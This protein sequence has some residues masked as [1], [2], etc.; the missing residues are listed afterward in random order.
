MVCVFREAYTNCGYSPF[1]SF[2]VIDLQSRVQ[3]LLELGA[4]LDGPIKYAEQ[5][6]I[7]ALR[8]PDGQMLSL[9]EAAA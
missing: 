2:E 4:V 1:L 7:A 3:S 5:G 9:F 6:K 8:G